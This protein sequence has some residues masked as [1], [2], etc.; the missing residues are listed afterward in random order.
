MPRLSETLQ[1]ER[2]IGRDNV[3]FGCV[4]ALM[5]GIIWV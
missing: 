5:I 4:F 2:G 3:V 1:P